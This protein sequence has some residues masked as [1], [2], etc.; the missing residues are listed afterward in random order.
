[1]SSLINIG[2]MNFF[3]NLRQEVKKTYETWTCDKW[4]ILSNT[5]NASSFSSF[6][7]EVQKK[8]RSSGQANTKTWL[9]HDY[10]ADC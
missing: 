2:F 6:I 3:V 1:M 8:K 5:E 7:Q 9:R 4:S 10:S